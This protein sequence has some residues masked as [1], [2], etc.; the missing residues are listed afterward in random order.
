MRASVGDARR[1]TRRS[2]AVAFAAVALAGLATAALG[3]DG[4]LCA[5]G[6]QHM[7]TGPMPDAYN[8]R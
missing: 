6:F 2:L 7:L 4:L 3:H 8:T 1:H 5:R